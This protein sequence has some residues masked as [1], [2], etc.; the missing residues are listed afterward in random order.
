M[1]RPFLMQSDVFSTKAQIELSYA[2][3]KGLF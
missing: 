3:E 2:V 1:L